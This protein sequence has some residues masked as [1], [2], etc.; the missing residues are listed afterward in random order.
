MLKPHALGLVF[1]GQCQYEV[2]YE[3][4]TVLMGLHGV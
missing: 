4:A 2:V 1:E 3:R